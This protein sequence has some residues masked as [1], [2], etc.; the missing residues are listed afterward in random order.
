[1]YTDQAV[2][3]LIPLLVLA[4][5]W[6]VVRHW[7]IPFVLGFALAVALGPSARPL[8]ASVWSSVAQ[9]GDAIFGTR[10]EAAEPR[11]DEWDRRPARR[12]EFGSD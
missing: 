9:V 11:R 7:I 6:V 10:H 2:S 12:G 5:L 8:L 4:V 1:M 3:I